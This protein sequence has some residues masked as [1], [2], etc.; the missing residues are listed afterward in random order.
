[1]EVLDCT[2]SLLRV[3]QK[4]LPSLTAQPALL[5]TNAGCCTEPNSSRAG[6]VAGCVCDTKLSVTRTL[7]PEPATRQCDVGQQLL[8]GVCEGS[9]AM[10]SPGLGGKRP[11]TDC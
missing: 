5:E 3:M 9:V 7:L 6:H 1:M 11:T 2:Q 4:A 8:R 10:R